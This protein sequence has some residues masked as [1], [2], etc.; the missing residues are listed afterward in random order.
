MEVTLDES[1]LTLPDDSTSKSTNTDKVDVVSLKTQT[2]AVSQRTRRIQVDIKVGIDVGIQCDLI[3]SSKSNVHETEFDNISTKT[4]DE[5]RIDEVEDGESDEENGD[6][7]YQYNDSDDPDYEDDSFQESDEGESDDED[8]TINY[9]LEDVVNPWEE[10]YYLV[11]ESSLYN[12]L[13]K[14][15]IC[16]M[17]SVPFIEYSKG[18]MICTSSVCSNGHICKWQSQ[19]CHNRLP[20][21][22]LLLASAI[23]TSGNNTSK[24]LRLLYQMKVKSPSARTVSRLQSAYTIPSIIEEF[25][26]QQA[27]LIQT[28]QGKLVFFYLLCYIK[29]QSSFSDLFFC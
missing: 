28:L 12:L 1:S 6:E 13:S 23:M 16:N 19:S 27:D 14:C 20:W 24:V 15:R 26:S 5:T 21:G 2:D 22:N 11:S 7:D 4:D 25:D 9:R 8:E 3:T 29:I 17:D 18:T 10:N